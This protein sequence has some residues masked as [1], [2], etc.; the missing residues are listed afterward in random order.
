[1]SLQSGS[2]GE[3]VKEWQELLS[4][5]G[6]NTA[7]DGVFGPNT[8]AQTRFLQQRLGVDVDGVVGPV[9][10]SA[11]RAAFPEFYAAVQSTSVKPGWEAW[12]IVFGV[13]VLGAMFFFGKRKKKA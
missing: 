7:A 3:A 12:G 5:A 13:T 4:H 10:L 2:R 8:E 1:M 9:T 11:A 6:L